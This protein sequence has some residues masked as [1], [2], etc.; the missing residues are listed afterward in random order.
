MRST[1]LPTSILLICSHTLG[2]KGFVT[3]RV[4]RRN[5]LKLLFASSDISDISN[6]SFEAMEGK[7]VLVVGGSGRVGGSVVTQLI[8]RGA[9]VTVG[10]TNLEKFQEAKARWQDL[11]DHL[12]IENVQFAKLNRETSDS[13]TVVLGN[14]QYDLVVHTAGPFQG[15]STTPNGVIEAC[16]SSKVPYIDVCDDYCTATAAK[17]KFSVTAKESGVPCVISTGCWV[18]AYR[19]NLIATDLDIHSL[20]IVCWSTARSLKFNGETAHTKSSEY[21]QNA[22]AGGSNC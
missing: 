18:S 5:A 12:P 9:E 2:V 4:D 17:T 13:V 3:R 8:K 6:I 19:D 1:L 22:K 14:Y 11:F 21:K 7:R 16:I 10:G 15:K 20:G